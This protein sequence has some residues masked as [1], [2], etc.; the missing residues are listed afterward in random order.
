MNDYGV[1]YWITSCTE[2][3]A[4]YVRSIVA[5][6]TILRVILLLNI[7]MRVTGGGMRGVTLLYRLIN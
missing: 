5:V 4:Q 2:H 6:L 7:L 3:V 1:L